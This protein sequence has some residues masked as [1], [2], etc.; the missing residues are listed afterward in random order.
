MTALL[1]GRP[2]ADPPAPA[3]DEARQPGRRRATP[4]LL[5]L[6]GALCLA[7]LFLAPLVF[8]LSQSLQTGSLERGYRLT[9]RFATYA[10]VLPTYSE[11]LVRSLVYASIATL[12]A[13][14][15]AYPLAYAIAFKSGRWKNVLLVLVIAP[16]FTSFLIRTLAWQTILTGEGPVT[17]F[18]RATHVLDL[19][20]ALH[21][22]GADQLLGT[23]LAVVTGLTYNFLPFMVLPLYASLERVDPRLLEAA[24]DL[25]ASPWTGFRKV[26]VPL[27]LPGAV[28]GT[29]LTFIPAAGDY[30]NSQLLGS[31]QTTMIG[32]VVAGQFLRVLDYPT[33]AALSVTL[34]FTIVVLVALYVRR[35]GTDELL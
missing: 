28:A 22:I 29:L 32:Q 7:L 24:G 16:F 18:L 34:M 31:P 15:I 8:L 30:I 14:L 25:Y 20:R 27:S 35:A 33:A 2:P 21:L 19:L 1:T 23:P 26:T 13:L 9:F 6:P 17:S 12:L 10:D 4:Y 5:L 3:E 11:Q